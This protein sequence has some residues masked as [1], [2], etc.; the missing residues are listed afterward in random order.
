[1]ASNFSPL[2][3]VN[4]LSDY[5][6]PSAVCIKPVQTVKKGQATSNLAG[7]VQI[8]V[9]EDVGELK[10]AEISLSDCL[11]CRCKLLVMF[12]ALELG[13]DVQNYKSLSSQHGCITSAESI[14]VSMQ[15]HEEV[16]R[17]L[18]ANPNLVPVVT[19]SPQ[20]LASLAAYH[21][22]SKRQTLHGIRHFF[23][24]VL[25][26]RLVLD[27]TFAH[28]LVLDQAS[29]ELISSLPT[30]MAAS[31]E[32]STSKLP[33][34]ILSSA[35]PGFVCYAEKTRSSADVLL[36]RLSKVKSPMAVMGWMVKEGWLSK[37]I[38][39]SKENIYHVSIMM[40]FDKKLEASRA[41]FH[42]TEQADSLT[43]ASAEPVRQV[44]CVLTTGELEKLMQSRSFSLS[45]FSNTFTANEDDEE[46]SILPS[47][48]SS[49]GTS[50]GSYLQNALQAFLSTLPPTRIPHLRLEVAHNRGGGD[51]EDYLLFEKDQIIFKGAKCYG[52]KNLQN[53]VRKVSKSS[54]SSDAAVPL[55][56]G[57][58]RARLNGSGINRVRDS[59]AVKVGEEK[60]YDYIEVMA[61]PSGCVNG[62]GQIPPPRELVK[63][64]EGMPVVDA[65]KSWIEQV[66]R[67]YWD[68]SVTL[69]PNGVEDGDIHPTILPLLIPKAN[70]GEWT[71][72]VKR[73][74]DEGK[75]WLSTSYR[76]VEDEEV[77][78]LAV[79]W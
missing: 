29:E 69:M 10:K 60:E 30:S 45:S 73:E 31:S 79:K 2:L 16:F 47:L 27:T 23:K 71:T 1:M 32:A 41:D 48:P 53:M 25:G 21:K 7:E 77:N 33:L 57:R 74:V 52:F 20:S 65:G 36:P 63:D 66:E 15:S 5:L 58:R 72:R 18:S 61:C 19:I 11:A 13:L 28:S 34:P 55:R 8:G 17:A 24:S 26:F 78:G 54:P 44:D 64:A 70:A 6:T 56:G 37:K 59:A 38:G 43:A 68:D 42:T 4:D 51:F 67:A 49:S 3:S 39:V 50:S 76:L 75:G 46:S 14:L 35:C 22:I 62:G 9:E 40:C 12:D